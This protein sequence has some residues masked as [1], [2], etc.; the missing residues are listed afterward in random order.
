MAT[1]LCLRCS[2]RLGGLLRTGSMA[3]RI[4]PNSTTQKRKYS[5]LPDLT[6]PITALTDK[7][8]EFSEQR[9][10]GYTPEQIFSLVYDVSRY[11]HF[12]PWCKDAHYLRDSPPES[13]AQLVIGFPPLC[14]SYTA[15]VHSQPHS[16]IRTVSTDGRLFTR[17]ENLWQFRRGPEL[18]TGPTTIVNFW[19]KFEFRSLVTARLGSLVFDE[20]ARTMTAAFESNCEQ[21]YG[22][23][24]LK[25]NGRGRLKEHVPLSLRDSNSV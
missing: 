1:S 11:K 20:V 23:S 21:V 13:L 3:A 7:N 15:T 6:N 8:K 5:F 19:V 12:L 9:I 18:R 10:I 2:K 22:A 24:H 25:Q 17:L 14:E 16:L 4:T